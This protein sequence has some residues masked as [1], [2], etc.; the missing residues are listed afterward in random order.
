MDVFCGMY[1]NEDDKNQ[2]DIMS[3]MALILPYRKKMGNYQFLMKRALILKWDKHP[4]VSGI[5]SYGPEIGIEESL[6]EIIESEAGYKVDPEA[7]KNLG[8]CS[9]SRDSEMICQLYAVDMQYNKT[10]DR[11]I[12]EKIIAEEVEGMF[13][14]DEEILLESLDSQL[15]ACYAKAHYLLL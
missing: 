11:D 6:A 9:T 5:V 2:E 3:R 12:P 15:I 4:D 1:I 7:F 13:W 14:G 8:L 10:S